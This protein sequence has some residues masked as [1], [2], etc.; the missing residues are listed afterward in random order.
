MPADTVAT[1]LRRAAERIER[2]GAWCQGASALG[3]LGIRVH[4]RSSFARKWDAIGSVER[5]TGGD[6]HAFY[7]ACRRVFDAAGRVPQ[8]WNDRPGRTAAEVAALLR[9]AADEAERSQ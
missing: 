8:G 5:E 7:E 1:I 3:P 4:P 9:R 6:V 2:P